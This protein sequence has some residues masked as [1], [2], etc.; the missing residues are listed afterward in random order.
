M[1]KESLLD[2]RDDFVD[3]CRRGPWWQ[4]LTALCL[5]LGAAFFLLW[6]RPL[7]REVKER[8][9]YMQDSVGVLFADGA[10]RFYSDVYVVILPNGTTESWS[11]ERFKERLVKQFERH[12]R[13]REQPHRTTRMVRFRWIGWRRLA[14]TVH[15]RGTL[16]GRQ[17]VVLDNL[18]EIDLT[19]EKRSNGWVITQMHIKGTPRSAEKAGEAQ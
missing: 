12:K 19:W 9:K 14:Q 11:R 3:F 18:N 17:G 5:L 7:P 6:V 1:D 2:L 8:L 16:Y 4:R 13:L 10:V 15:M